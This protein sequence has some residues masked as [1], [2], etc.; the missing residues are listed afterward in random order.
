M[1]VVM[2]YSYAECN[3]NITINK[4]L[5]LKSTSPKN[6][7]VFLITKLGNMQFLLR[8]GILNFSI[9]GFGKIGFL[10]LKNREFHNT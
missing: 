10:N 6:S 4:I 5:T 7:N 9:V 2:T 8:V 3:P 1:L